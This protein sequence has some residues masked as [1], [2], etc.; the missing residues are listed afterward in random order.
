ME[1]SGK[2]GG[3]GEKKNLKFKSNNK[4]KIS[5]RYFGEGKK[6][7]KIDIV[8]SVMFLKSVTEENLFCNEKKIMIIMMMIMMMVIINKIYVNLN[9]TGRKIDRKF[10]F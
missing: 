5:R 1:G 10:T 9:P 2:N 6:K 8:L 3:G 7:Y 4:K